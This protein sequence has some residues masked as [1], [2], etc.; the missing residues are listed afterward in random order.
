M[1]FTA[2]LLAASILPISAPA[3]AQDAGAGKVA[4]SAAGRAGQRQLH[5]REVGGIEPLLRIRNR[6][7]GRVQSRIRNRIDRNYDPQANI[8]TDGTP[9]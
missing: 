4:D 8:N 2:L 1:R 3:L 6:L 9:R 5:N 7:Q